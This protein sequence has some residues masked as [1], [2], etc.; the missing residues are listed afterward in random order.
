MLSQPGVR[1]VRRGGSQGIMHRSAGD[2]TIAVPEPT[3]ADLRREVLLSLIR[4]SLRPRAR[5]EAGE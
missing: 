4:Q 1:E 3:H 5:R 2:P